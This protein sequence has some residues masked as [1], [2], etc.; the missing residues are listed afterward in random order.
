RSPFALQPQPQPLLPLAFDHPAAAVFGLVL[1]TCRVS[2]TRLGL[3]VVPVHVLGALAVGPDVLARDR[4]GVAADAL[5]QVK[6]H[7]NLRSEFHLSPPSSYSFIS[8]YS[9]PH[10]PVAGASRTATTVTS[11]SS[12]IPASG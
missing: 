9:L 8:S 1:P 12:V 5:V 7:R 10:P 4:A 2:G 6:D 11:N 3:H